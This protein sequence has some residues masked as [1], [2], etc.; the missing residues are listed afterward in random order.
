MCRQLRDALLS[1]LFLAPWLL[2]LLMPI[3]AFAMWIWRLA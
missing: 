2:L 3:V 1:V